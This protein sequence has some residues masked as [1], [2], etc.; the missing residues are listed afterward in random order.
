MP[1]GY[2]AINYGLGYYASSAEIMTFVEAIR[3]DKIRH[4]LFY[5]GVN[6]VSRYLEKVE[7]EYKQ[8]L[9]DHLGFYHPK[10]TKLSML[11]LLE[12]EF[13]IPHEYVKHKSKRYTHAISDDD[14]NGHAKNII[15]I[16]FDNMKTIKGI[17]NS[18]DIE[19]VFFWQ[20]TL[21][22]KA[23]LT[24]R[25]KRIMQEIRPNLVKLIHAVDKEL[26]QRKDN[27]PARLYFFGEL[28]SQLDAQEHFSDWCHVDNDA[29]LLIAQFI[30]DTLHPLFPSVFPGKNPQT[31]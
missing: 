7:I 12:E 10:H 11:N 2:H 18:Y 9:F 16:Y 14:A 5:D 13:G 31:K 20:P 30:A 6:E 25:E 8:R 17:A 27:A 26:A 21:F 15:D 28:F 29:N 24:D 3:R 23:H 4:A 22:N 1:K 19:P